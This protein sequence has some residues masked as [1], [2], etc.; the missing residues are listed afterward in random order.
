VRPCICVI[1]RTEFRRN[2][3]SKNAGLCCSRACGFVLLRQRRSNRK[4]ESAGR[5]SLLVI[6][7]TALRNA[8]RTHA[9]GTKV[10]RSLF[11]SKK[12]ICTPRVCAQCGTSFIKAYGSL[13]KRVWGRWCSETCR[14]SWRAARQQPTRLYSRGHIGSPHAR[15]AQF[16]GVAYELGVTRARVFK[17]D[18]WAC[19]ICARPTLRE[20]QGRTGPRDGRLPELDHIIPLSKGGTHTWANVQTLCR[21]C[22]SAKGDVIETAADT[23]RRIE[24]ELAA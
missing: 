12:K 18:G 21:R 16:Y 13:R 8:A 4:A 20:K 19:Q 9:S 10:Q 11:Y 6:S 22:N 14:D 3:R 5:R 17:R 23:L 7:L 1:C 2:T 24:G 15:R